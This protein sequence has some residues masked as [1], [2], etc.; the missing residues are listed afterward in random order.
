MP[1]YRCSDG[2]CSR[3]FEADS[4]DEAMDTAADY[5]SEGEYGADENGTQRIE[6]TVYQLPASVKAKLGDNVQIDGDMLSCCESREATH[7]ERPTEP[8]CPHGDHDFVSDIEHEGGIKENPGTFGHGGAVVCYSHCK[9]CGLPKTDDFW[10]YD[11]DRYIP[12]GNTSY[13][14]IPDDWPSQEDT[15]D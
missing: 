14:E 12:D 4:W 15:D 1:L 9:H 5:M 13:G 3:T 8:E 2:E 6:Y 7:V 11:L 10:D